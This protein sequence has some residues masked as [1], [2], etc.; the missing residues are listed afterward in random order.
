M[1]DTVSFFDGNPTVTKP[2][3]ADRPRSPADEKAAARV[4]DMVSG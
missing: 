1:I 2:T 4:F 3:N